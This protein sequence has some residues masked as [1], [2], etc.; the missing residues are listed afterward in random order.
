MYQRS[1]LDTFPMKVAR[2]PFLIR[3]SLALLTVGLGAWAVTT[4][5]PDWVIA[6]PFGGTATT[7]A[8]DPKTDGVVLAGGR[9]SL[10]FRSQNG[11]DKW[12]LLDFPKRHLSEVTSILV[13]PAD[14]QHYLAGMISADGGALFDSRDAGKTW[15]VVSDIHDFGVR[16]LAVAPSNAARFVAGT[17]HGVMLSDDSG[18]TWKRVSDPQNFEMSSVTAVAVDSANPDIIYAG[19]SHLPWKTTDGGKTWQSIHTGMIDDSDVFSIY[20]DPADP[21]NV[22]A[23]ACSGIYATANRGDQWR[24]LLGIPNTSRRTHVIRKD[25]SGAIFAGTT[26]GLFKSSSQGTTWKTMTSDQVNWMAFDPAHPGSLYLAIENEGIGKSANGGDTVQMVNHG[27]VDRTISAVA[28]SGTKLLALETQLGATSGIFVSADR[29]E[30]W[31]QLGNVRGLDGVHLAKIVGMPSE[32]RILLAASRRQLYKSIDAGAAWKAIPV[33][34]VIPPPPV[35]ETK[36]VKKVVASK[37]TAARGK[38]PVRRAAARKP[39][40]KIRTASLSEV[41][42]LYTIKRGAKDVLFA[43]T[44]LGLLISG[45]AGERWTLADLPASMPVTG[46]YAA[47][48]NDGRLVARA[49]AGLFE[50]KDFGDHWTPLAFPL[51]SSDVNE[52]A[53]PASA[54]LPILVATR[55]GLYSS[56]DGGAKWFANLGGIPASTVN[57]V[58]FGADKTAYAV[59]YGRLYETTDA[60]ASWTVAPSVLPATRIRQLWMPDLA[61]NRL[62]GITSDLGVLFRN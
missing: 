14:A 6:G 57:S 61:S 13:D 10:L 53:I 28:Q 22:F 5:A 2:T 29:G 34:I 16:A 47:P 55:V 32:D 24:K 19:T 12:D 36:E 62:Y 20:V 18:K 38:Q 59:E 40:E 52:V 33:R 42:G 44:D 48:N 27:F 21:A 41:S 15:A 49:S 46:L 1:L 25:P 54:D 3:A 39:V 60:G 45:D 26:M 51:P 30:S 8:L 23:S 9:N 4:P 58:L 37:R 11:G 43:A 31:S 35:Q 17:G 50:S 7:V 56:P